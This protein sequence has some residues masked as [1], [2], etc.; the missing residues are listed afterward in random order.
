[1]SISSEVE[2]LEAEAWAQMHWAWAAEAPGVTTVKRWGRA[3][4]LLTPAVR[5][6]AVNRVLGLGCAAP[7]TREDLADIAEF[8]RV[9]GQ[10]RWFVEWSPEARTAEPGLLATAGGILKDH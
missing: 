2:L 9:G 10:T 5:A 4:G 1:M 7:L 3:T 6:V 8:F